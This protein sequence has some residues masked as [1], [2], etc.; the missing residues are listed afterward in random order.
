MGSIHKSSPR[1]IDSKTDAIINLLTRRGLVG[2]K[3]INNDVVRKV[4]Q[5]KKR[6]AY[7][8]THSLLK[9]YRNI[10]WLLECFPDTVAEAIEHSFETVDELIDRVDIEVTLGNRKL[11]NRIENIKKTRLVLDR[12]NEALT[13]L[14]KKPDDGERLNE[15]IYLTYISHEILNH[16]ELLY[17]LN[18]SSR[19]YYRL[20]EQAILIISLRLWSAPEQDVDFWLEIIMLLE[21]E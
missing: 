8:N 11:E 15:L 9:Q 5:K 10:S 19:H 13:V 2:D 21:N 17:R 12:V 14:K 6:N 7:H 16:N 18:L 20:R 3:N 4:Q 1:G